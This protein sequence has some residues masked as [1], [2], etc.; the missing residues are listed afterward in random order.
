MPKFSQ[1]LED[2]P[3]LGCQALMSPP[4]HTSPD[5]DGAG[6]D[7]LAP[8]PPKDT[9]AKRLETPT[10]SP[11]SQRIRISMGWE[12]QFCSYT[13]PLPITPLLP[14]TI[15]RRLS[16]QIQRQVCR[17]WKSLQKYP[18]AC[19]SVPPQT[20]RGKTQDKCLADKQRKLWPGSPAAGLTGKPREGRQAGCKGISRELLGLHKC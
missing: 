1:F 7:S 9:A 6:A 8:P 5:R 11:E 15:A 16:P 17:Q 3:N 20:P 4:A 10:L 13:H 14:S 19:F 18:F 2:P 12:R